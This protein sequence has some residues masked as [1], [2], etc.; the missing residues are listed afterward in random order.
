MVYTTQQRREIVLRFTP[1]DR[2][3]CMFTG[4]WVKATVHSCW[5]NE[6]TWPTDTWAPYQLKLD[7]GNL[8]FAPADDDRVVRRVADLALE[9]NP[10]GSSEET[11]AMSVDFGALRLSDSMLDL[12]GT[13]LPSPSGSVDAESSLARARSVSLASVGSVGSLCSL[14]RASDSTDSK[15]SLWNMTLPPGDECA[16]PSDNLFSDAPTADDS[17]Q[18]PSMSAHGP[19]ISQLFSADEGSLIFEEVSQ[20]M[21]ISPASA[22]PQTSHDPWCTGLSP[23]PSVGEAERSQGAARVYK[24]SLARSMTDEAEQLRSHALQQQADCE[25]H[26]Q[27]VQTSPFVGHARG[28]TVVPTSS[29]KLPDG[30]WTAFATATQPAL[31]PAANFQFVTSSKLH[32]PEPNGF[33]TSELR[34]A[35]SRGA[36]RPEMR[37]MHEKQLARL[38][39]LQDMLMHARVEFGI[40]DKRYQ[41]VRRRVV[42]CEAGLATFYDGQAL[43]VGL[44][45]LSVSKQQGT[46]PSA[47]EIASSTKRAQNSSSGAATS[48]GSNA[49]SLGC[50]PKVKKKRVIPPN[51]DR[52]KATPWSEKE[53]SDFRTLLEQEGP[54]DWKGKAVRLGTGRSVKS[55]HTRWLR[56]EGRIIDLPRHRDPAKRASALQK[57]TKGIAHI[58]SSL[59]ATI[60]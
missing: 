52:K 31:T 40:D 56:D 37:L 57:A 35:A 20:D 50:Q 16:E 42:A 60:S 39:G 44:N 51:P 58:T 34:A 28:P 30:Q 22:S 33:L 25:Q 43:E 26:Q 2:V 27:S 17:M 3:E 8:I 23:L 49:A 10:T 41:E 9:A 1:G 54:G 46:A 21:H 7:D 14:P 29:L 36:L 5:Y 15:V 53:L 45:P 59:T 6:P 13:N 12:C 11:P 24:M 47:S 19:A 48:S 18:L 4:T 55:L 38:R 32:H